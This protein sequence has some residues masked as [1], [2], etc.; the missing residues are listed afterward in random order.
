MILT[1]KNRSTRRKKKLANCSHK[2]TKN[3]YV[4]CKNY[5]KKKTGERAAIDYLKPSCWHWKEG[6]RITTLHVALC[7]TVLGR[8][9]LLSCY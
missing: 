3:D 4:P 6:V 7:C 8:T 2:R 5:L 1:G 9:D